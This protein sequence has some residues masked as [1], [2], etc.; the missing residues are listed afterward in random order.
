MNF[1]NI[2]EVELNPLQNQNEVFAMQRATTLCFAILAVKMC[3]SK[4]FNKTPQSPEE[5]KLKSL[6][7]EGVDKIK[8]TSGIPKGFNPSKET[9]V[10]VHGYLVNSYLPLLQTLAQRLKKK[11]H[12]VLLIDWELGAHR[13]YAQAAA[14]TQTVGAF[15][16]QVLKKNK[17]S[18]NKVHILGQGLGAH[19]AAETG[20]LSKAKIGRITGLDPAG[21]LFEASSFGIN[22]GSAQFVDVIH[23][24]SRP[25]GYG[26]QKPCGHIDIYVNGGRRQPGCTYNPKNPVNIHDLKKATIYKACGHVKA[27]GYYIETIKDSYV[28]P[29]SYI[30]RKEHKL[31]FS[32]YHIALSWQGAV[33]FCHSLGNRT[34]LAVLDTG[35]K[36]ATVAENSDTNYYYWLG[37]SYNLPGTPSYGK[38][39]FYWNSGELVD[40]SLIS[41]LDF[42]DCLEMDNFEHPAMIGSYTCSDSTPNHI[43][44]EFVL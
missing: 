34:R 18:W 24:D 2:G 25:N 3:M 13:N 9:D 31:C 36:I 35:E 37:A 40:P 23:T 1:L 28:C 19:V 33:D 26:I 22:K 38:D 14:N 10:I 6:W 27:I 32:V 39:A 30:W 15:L 4:R 42:G 16:Y 43:I 11:N 20:K 21:P 5:M 44:C 7:I 8:D 29:N 41:Y 12:N 17:I